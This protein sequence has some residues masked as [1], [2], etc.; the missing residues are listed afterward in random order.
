MIEKLVKCLRSP[1][2]ADKLGFRDA[3]KKR[4]KGLRSKSFTWKKRRY[5]ILRHKVCKKG[6][7]VIIKNERAQEYLVPV[8]A[9]RFF[10][11]IME[12]KSRICWSTI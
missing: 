6:N 11:N 10:Q 8:F 1:Q 3:L 4:V 2:R 5:K 12:K 7:A 9:F